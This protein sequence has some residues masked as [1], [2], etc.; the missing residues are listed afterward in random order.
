M[1]W[2]ASDVHVVCIFFRKP[3]THTLWK[4]GWGG[5]RDRGVGWGAKD[6]AC[7]VKKRLKSGELLIHRCH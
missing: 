6:V 3:H 7:C 1:G 4:R 5:V 2:G